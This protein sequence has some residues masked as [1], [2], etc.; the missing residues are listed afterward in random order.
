[1]R[2]FRSILRWIIVPDFVQVCRRC[3][4]PPFDHDASAVVDGGRKVC[5]AYLPG[6]RRTL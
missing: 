5:S 3:G 6:W 4:R 1:M 2:W